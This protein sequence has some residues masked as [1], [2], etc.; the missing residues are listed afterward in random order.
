MSSATSLYSCIQQLS[1]TLGISCGAAALEASMALNHHAVPEVADFTAAFLVV[2]CVCLLA[3]PASLAMPHDA[4]AEL[5]GRPTGRP[6]GVPR[7]APR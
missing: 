7:A 1:M 5:A 3:A 6:G 4:G 2:S